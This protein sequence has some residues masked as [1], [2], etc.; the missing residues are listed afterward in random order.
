MAIKRA[1]LKSDPP[2]KCSRWRII[3]YNS[4]THKQEWFTVKGTK[5][6]AQEFERQQRSKLASG[7]FIPREKRKTF[8]TVAEDFLAHRRGQACRT[9]TLACYKT[10]LD[11]HL[12]PRFA[13]WEV[14]RI[15]RS[16][17]RTYMN[18]LRAGGATVS[19]CNRIIRTMKAVLFYALGEELV[20]RNVM[21]RFDLIQ[22]GEDERHVVRQPFTVEE[23]AAIRAAAKGRE[24]LFFDILVATGLRPAELYALAW[25]AIDLQR[26]ALRVERSWDHR[27]KKFVDPKTTSGRREVRLVPELVAELEAHREESGGVGLLFP[28]REGNPMNPANV[29]RDIWKPLLKRAQVAARDIYSARH[30]YASLARGNGQSAFNVGQ[31]MG[32]RH[33]KLV[34]DVYA[35][36]L[37]E[38]LASVAA[39]VG[40]RVFGK[41][42][43]RAID[44][45]KRDVS[46]PLDDASQAVAGNA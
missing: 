17:V 13:G 34:D 45:G 12:L 32:H 33:S 27:G 10:V 43:L 39:A 2:G 15:R 4:M 5:Q 29:R 24:R 22:G 40:S 21:H 9:S 19:T 42:K 8:A 20:E 35:D 25:E 31:S 11:K 1:P 26:G 7:V 6:Q 38:G 44:G 3:I 30:T 23:I 41:P 18:E 28:T 14:N 16:D 36:I 46:E 37:P